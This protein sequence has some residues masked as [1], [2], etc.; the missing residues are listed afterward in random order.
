MP[1][2]RQRRRAL[3]LLLLLSL[4]G[5]ISGMLTAVRRFSAHSSRFVE[6]RGAVGV[7]HDH[8]PHA[9]RMRTQGASAKGLDDEEPR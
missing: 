7:I 8:H 5:F 2:G 6:G 9:P 4:V 1:V 3:R